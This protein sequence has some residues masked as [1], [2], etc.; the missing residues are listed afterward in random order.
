MSRLETCVPKTNEPLIGMALA[1]ENC[2]GEG[3]TSKLG[4]KSRPE[5]HGLFVNLLWSH[6]FG[7]CSEWSFLFWL[8]VLSALLDTDPDVAFPERIFMLRKES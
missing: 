6:T 4:F 5:H 2:V 1:I 7:L 8:A 3:F